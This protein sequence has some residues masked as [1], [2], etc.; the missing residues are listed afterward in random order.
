MCLST[1]GDEGVRRACSVVG[2]RRKGSG[3]SRA[4]HFRRQDA[5]K[6]TAMQRLMRQ[7]SDYGVHGRTPCVEWNWGGIARA[8]RLTPQ[9]SRQWALAGPQGRQRASRAAIDGETGVIPCAK[10]QAR[11]PLL[12]PPS[13]RCRRTAEKPAPSLPARNLRLCNSMC[14]PAARKS[15]P[16]PKPPGAPEAPTKASRV[17][18]CC[19]STPRR[20]GDRARGHR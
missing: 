4:Q 13:P 5:L 17:R 6:C 9:R 10:R 12:P 19:K 14:S 7:G 1:F 3:D 8:G 16:G 15:A 11:L 20:S 18:P 2:P